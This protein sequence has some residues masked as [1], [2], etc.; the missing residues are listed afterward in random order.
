MLRI[1]N[2]K[3]KFSIVEEQQKD[4]KLLEQGEDILRLSSQLQFYQE[5]QAEK[6][7]EFSKYE[8]IP[9]RFVFFFSY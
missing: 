4:Q 5:S 9:V 6:D 8:R 3:L 2:N 7:N 1:E